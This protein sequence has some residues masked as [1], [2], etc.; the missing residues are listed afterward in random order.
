MI[1]AGRQVTTV[2]HVSPSGLP[3]RLAGETWWLVLARRWG[4]GAFA[5]HR[6]LYVES[7]QA[8]VRIID[9]VGLAKA[10]GLVLVVG[11]AIRR[12]RT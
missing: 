3:V 9:F 12:M 1:R 4:G 8:C 7:G 2:D 10:L 11:A 5:Y 6:P